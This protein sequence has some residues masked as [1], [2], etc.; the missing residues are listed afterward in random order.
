MEAQQ[1]QALVARVE[2]LAEADPKGYVRRVFAIAALGF[3]ILGLVIAMA[4]VNVALIGGVVLLV[5]FSGGKALLFFAKLGK[6]VIV[7]AIPVWL[8]LRTTWTLVFAR[9][10]R[11]GGRE[12]RRDEAAALFARLDAMRERI[13]GPRVHRVLLTDELNAAIVQRPRLGLLGWQENTLILGLRLLQALSEDEAMAVVAHEYGHLAGN[14]GRFAAF[15]Y[16]FRNAWG[17]LQAMSQQWNDW[18]SRLIARLFRWYAPRFNAY[19]FALARQNEYLADRTSVELVGAGPAADALMRTGITARYESEGFW[20]AIQRRIAAEAE[21]PADRGLMWRQSQRDAL[22]AEARQRYLDAARREATDPF[23]THPA[24]VD[25]LAAIGAAADGQAAQ[26]LAPPAVSAAESWFG[27][28]LPALSAEFDRRWR[29]EVADQWKERHE[30]LRRQAAQRCR[31]G[32]T[33]RTQRRRTLGPPLRGR[34]DRPRPRLDAAPRRLARGGAR[35]PAGA[36][37]ARPPAPRARRRSRHRR[38]RTCDRRRS[39]G[40]PPWLRH[41]LAVL[42]P[43]R[44]RR[45]RRAG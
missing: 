17:R 33:G 29:D 10:P 5:V 28:Q 4:M 40:Y 15:I 31:A 14:H 37:P 7:L 13:G 9:L 21:P 6:L 34:G 43:P 18:G 11:P 32:D 42:P 16:R 22:D 39:L 3:V 23:D 44:C 20:P 26:R 36:V 30:H 24:L 35:P 38:P 45:R 8:M 19:T 25:R 1:F 41:R 2:R 27:A 12:I